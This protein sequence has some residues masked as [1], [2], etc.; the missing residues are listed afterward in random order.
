[1]IT[2]NSKQVMIQDYDIITHVSDKLCRIIY[3]NKEYNFIGNNIKVISLD[4]EQC[5]I[6]IDLES[7]IIK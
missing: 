7:I 6:N 5:Y 4:Q 2:I 3:Q 1:M